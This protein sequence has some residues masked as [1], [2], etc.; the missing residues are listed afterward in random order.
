MHWLIG[1]LVFTFGRC[2]ARERMPQGDYMVTYEDW[3][4]GP[5]YRYREI[6]EPRDGH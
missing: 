5:I 6:V 4:W 1:K 2:T 3:W